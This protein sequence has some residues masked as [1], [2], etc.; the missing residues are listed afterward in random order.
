MKQKFL[1][2]TR[3]EA[4][5]L[6]GTLPI[7]SVHGTALPK[8]PAILLS[9]DKIA[10][11]LDDAMKT[12]SFDVVSCL[13][14]GSIEEYQTIAPEDFLLMQRKSLTEKSPA[15]NQRESVANQLNSVKSATDSYRSLFNSVDQEPAH[16]ISKEKSI[17]DNFRG[18]SKKETAYGDN[19]P[20]N[21][22]ESSES[23]NR[24]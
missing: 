20:H 14:P 7:L 23:D 3:E 22:G 4:T 2:A 21:G 16:N 19:V 9:S 5:S 10:P 24:Y 18:Y 13:P 6:E 11:P 15:E 1:L 17:N 12:K 8:E